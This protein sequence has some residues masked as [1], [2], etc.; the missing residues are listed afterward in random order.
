M[1]K[2]RS[3]TVSILFVCFWIAAVFGLL[4]LPSLFKMVE[5]KR[6]INVFMWSGVVDTKILTDF[7]KETGI[8]VN[9]SYFEGNDELIVKVLATKGRGYDMIV[10]SD[11]AV[12][13]FAKQGLLK[14]LDI[15]KL[16]FFNQ[17]DPKFLHHWFDPQN[18]YSV[19]AEWYVLG[20]GINK[21]HFPQGL[22]EPSL[23]T[24]FE[25]TGTYRIGVINDPKELAGLA[26]KYRY[27]QLRSLEKEETEEIKKVLTRQ[28]S[29]VEAYTDFR[30]DFLLES[31]NCSVVLVPIS[32]IWQT[33]LSDDSVAFVLPQEGTFLGLEN[34]A[35]LESSKKEELVYQFMNYLFR[36]DVQKHNFQNCIFLST[37]KDA[38]FV[39]EH[40]ILRDCLEKVGMAY[41]EA[42]LFENVLT[43]NQVNDIWMAVKGL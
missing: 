7:E 25:P 27:G 16:D 17:I 20:L 3:I 5:T 24:I 39:F 4:Y 40:K 6:S 19:P 37:R 12:A 14:K 35:I 15:N 2:S 26:I 38:Q 22:P 28:K 42:Q 43:D 11:W 8:K 30:G 21:K 31:G 36:L 23:K 32:V 10:P 9:V 13:F 29:F 34:Y 41:G 1:V 18:D 33:V